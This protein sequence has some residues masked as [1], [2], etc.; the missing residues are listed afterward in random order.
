VGVSVMGATW[1]AGKGGGVLSA[2]DSVVRMGVAATDRWALAIA[3][4]ARVEG[5]YH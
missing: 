3:R 4:V 5:V 2:P 1:R